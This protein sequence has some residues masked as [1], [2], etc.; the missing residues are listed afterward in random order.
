MSMKNQTEQAD[1][2]ENAT[3]SSKITLENIPAGALTK[4]SLA[5]GGMTC[6]ACVRR[7]ENTLSGL[8][9]VGQ[10]S[11]NLATER[12][13]VEY[14]PRPGRSRSPSGRP[15]IDAGYEIRETASA[16]ASLSVGGM[17]CAACVR[18]VENALG[19]LP[20]VSRASVNLATGKSDH[21]LRPR[22]DRA[23]GF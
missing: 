6:A 22:G 7:V 19:D 18:R 8:P 1:Q 11:V 9:G 21:R 17:T 15:I 20:G 16:T 5:V 12:A 10:A 13:T 3:G 14:D 4:T 23:G 2:G